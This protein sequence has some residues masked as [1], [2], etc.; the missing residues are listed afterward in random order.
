M[1]GEA[2]AISTE[3]AGVSEEAVMAPENAAGE[4]AKVLAV[5]VAVVAVEVAE[6]A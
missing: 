4:V 2:A 6:A 5:N 3:V 1:A